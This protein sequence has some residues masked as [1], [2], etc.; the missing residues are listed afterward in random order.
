MTDWLPWGFVMMV[1]T[2]S[3]LALQ[4]RALAQA[5]VGT[6]PDLKAAWIGL[7][8]TALASTILFLLYVFSGESWIWYLR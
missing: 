7:T 6:P 4:L 3:T 5:P 2:F 1:G 8:L